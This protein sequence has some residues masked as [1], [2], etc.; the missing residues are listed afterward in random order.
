MESLDYSN[1]ESDDVLDWLDDF[2]ETDDPIRFITYAVQALV[3]PSDLD[4]DLCWE[5]LAAC[6]VIAALKG[7]P[8]PE[9]P[10]GVQDWV[11]EHG[12]EEVQQL[13]SSALKAIE[14]ITTKSEL[15]DLW[16]DSDEFSGWLA[17]QT[18]L[19]ARLQP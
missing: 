17:V 4:V 1:F 16:E 3:K 6:E 2:V 19:R 10:E 8:S 18:D 13:L 7:A 5:A 9:L 11:G 14:Q 15:K 12:F